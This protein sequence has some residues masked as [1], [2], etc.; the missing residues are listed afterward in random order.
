[1]QPKVDS[2]NCSLPHF[3]LTAILYAGIM[4]RVCTANRIHRQGK[5]PFLSPHRPNEESSLS[6]TLRA[7]INVLSSDAKV[8]SFHAPKHTLL[9]PS[10]IPSTRPPAPRLKILSPGPNLSFPFRSSPTILNGRKRHLHSVAS[11][12]FFCSATSAYLSSS[13]LTN[14][15]CKS[16]KI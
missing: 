10:P 11:S 16:F 4:N 13:T 6:H 12:R 5:Q 3:T 2:T 8:A 1:M 15:A 14:N 9:S 7:L